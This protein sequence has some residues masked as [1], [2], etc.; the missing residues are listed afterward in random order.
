M[1]GDAD[2]DVRE[3]DELVNYSLYAMQM[4]PYLEAFGPGRVL[5]VFLERMR[6]APYA[7]LERIARFVGAKGDVAAAEQAEERNASASRLRSGLFRELVVDSAPGRRAR[8]ALVPR[9]VREW[10]KDRFYRMR[11]RPELSD[12]TRAELESKFDE[13]LS[14]LGGMLG[15]DAALTCADFTEVVSSLE[16]PAFVSR[17]AVG[18]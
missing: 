12:E 18:E 10:V 3:H 13:D 1:P 9:P 14:E 6:V 8:R 17:E 15:I 5:P 16:S 4:R 2:R 11:S 7:E